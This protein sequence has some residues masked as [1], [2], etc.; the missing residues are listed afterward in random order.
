MAAWKSSVLSLGIGIVLG[1]AI[2]PL[3]EKPEEHFDCAGSIT[4]GSQTLP[5]HLL[6][7]ARFCIQAKDLDAATKL[8]VLA[9]AYMMIDYERVIGRSMPTSLTGSLDALRRFF[10]D[11]SPQEQSEF[12]DHLAKVTLSSE[13]EKL[14]LWLK[15]R[16]VP[17]YKPVYMERAGKSLGSYKKTDFNLEAAWEVIVRASAACD[18]NTAEQLRKNSP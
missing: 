17:T 16:P 9:S 11:L 13:Q 10:V 14:C 1:L 3:I 18:P 7:G 5:E 15:T 4:P 6:H 2:P 8:Y 12:N